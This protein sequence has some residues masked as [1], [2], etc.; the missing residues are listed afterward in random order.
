MN[1]RFDKII[2]LLLLSLWL[3]CDEPPEIRQYRIPKSRSDLGDLGKD[4]PE[5]TPVAKRV[6]SQMFVAIESRPDATWFFKLTGPVEAMQATQDEW[7]QMLAEIEFTETGEL[8]YEVSD[9]WKPGPPRQFRFAT[10]FR[11]IEGKGNIEYSISKLGPDQDL[12]LNVNRWL[13]QLNKPPIKKDALKLE[14]MQF[15]SGEFETFDETGMFDPGS[16]MPGQSADP[17]EDPGLSYDVPDGWQKGPVN[18]I[19]KVRLLYGDEETAP[20]I[21]VT[22]LAAAAN[23]WIPN[24]QRWARQVEMDESAEF[25]EK[26]ST[27]VTIDGINGHKI[28]LIPDD[29]EKQRALVGI[30]IVR[31]ELAWFFKFFGNKDLITKHEPDFDKFVKSFSF[32]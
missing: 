25:A 19:V 6:L 14:T 31:E 2:A 12:L 24:A 16:M 17:P 23:K 22:Q 10:Y 1:R 4:P 3:G 26:N 29:E 30:M 20:Q 32:K 15:K 7:T 18:S 13:G 8:D 21:S 9:D 27:E 28:R 11:T 5:S